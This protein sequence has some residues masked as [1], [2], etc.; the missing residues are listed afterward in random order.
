MARRKN[1]REIE[2]DEIFLDHKNPAGFHQENLEG[3]IENPIDREIFLVLGGIFAFLLLLFGLRAGYLQIVKGEALRERSEKNYLRVVSQQ[4][5]RGAIYDRDGYP[6]AYDEIIDGKPVRK[7]PPGGF[8]HALGY[9]TSLKNSGEAPKGVS[10]LEATYNDVLAGTAN[11]TIEE[12]D[13]AGNI[14]GSGILEAGEPG[15]A[16]LTSISKDL[17]IKLAEAIESTVSER[18]FL[19]GAGVIMDVKTGEILALVSQPEFDPNLLITAEDS[20]KIEKLLSDAGK[21]F[22]NRAVSG[23]YPPGS[24]VK[25]ALAAGALTEGIISPEKKILSTGSISLPNPYDSSRPNVFLDWKA[26]GWVDMREAIANS[27]DVYFYE[28]GGGYKDQKGL[29]AWNIKKYLS[30]FGFADKS[31]IDLPEEKTGHLPDP[32][33]KQ[34]GRDWTIGDTYHVSIGQGNI[35]VTPIQMAVYAS[36]IAT[37]GIIP[38]PHLARAILDRDKKPVEILDYPPKQTI[39]LSPEIFKVIKEGMRGAVEFGTAEGL[40]ALPIEVA[41][42]TGTAETGEK[43]K[44]NSWSIGFFPYDKPRLA[45]AILMEKG[46]E[47]NSVGAT[48]VASQLIRWIADTGFLSKLNDDIL[49]GSK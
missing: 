36:A 39:Q 40:Y 35:T 20:A 42:K 37:D 11:K 2:I 34:G 32:T 31:G 12:I 6:L 14:V 16:I 43:Q 13:A 17:E 45:F 24:I 38:Y 29:G 8:L 19:G 5:Q 4:N 22:L 18:G 47:A 27:S 10:G 48:Y 7:Y 26:L 44:V 3:V 21:P 25:P 9:L 1:N 23:L 46:P 49:L 15:E 30:M 33:E 28:I 41:A